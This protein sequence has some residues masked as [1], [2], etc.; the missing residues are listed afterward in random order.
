MTTPD[1]LRKG[2]FEKRLNI[3]YLAQYAPMA[4]AFERIS[5]ED[6]GGYPAYHYNVYNALCNLGFSVFSARSPSVLLSRAHS[7]D[8]VYS[9]LNRMPVRNS[10]ILVSA[11]C[12]YVKL[13]YLGACP[14][15]RAL[16][17]DKLLFKFFA[18]AQG[19]PVPRGASYLKDSTLPDTAPFSPPYFVKDRKG[20][21]SENITSKNLADNWAEAVSVATSLQKI[22]KDVL[23]EEY[24]SG[25]DITVPVVG[26]NPFKILGI[27]QPC[28]D[29]PGGILT[30]DLKLE[31]RLGYQLISPDSFLETTVHIHTEKLWQTFGPIDYFRLDYRYN[32]A[33]KSLFLL[34][35]NI[36][37]HFEAASAIALAASTHDISY[38]ELLQHIV[39]YS[40]SRQLGNGQQAEWVL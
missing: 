29:A 18:Q 20:A 15:T 10:E 7:I 16:A 4:P 27:V 5:F 33:T 40:Y 35:A 37:C 11:L 9:L 25:V 1:W 17:E 32:Q 14:A 2:S 34:E 19:I 30:H 36:C 24:C 38:P 26:A 28:S 12:E 3:L 31:D 8:Y 39:A 21:A 6:D 13:P 23:I 22:G